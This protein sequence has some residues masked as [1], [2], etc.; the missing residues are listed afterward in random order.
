MAKPKTDW[1]IDGFKFKIRVDHKDAQHVHFRVFTGKQNGTLAL[2]GVLIMTPDEYSAF[3]D[4][5]LT[6]AEKSNGRIV[7]EL[8]FNTPKKT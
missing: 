8:A 5:L 2:A 1:D 6:G 7:L 3:T 4:A